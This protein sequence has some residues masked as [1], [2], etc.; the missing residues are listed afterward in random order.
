MRDVQ[1]AEAREPG[2]REGRAL[3]AALAAESLAGLDVRLR[4]RAV[5]AA[6]SAA[7]RLAERLADGAAA[8]LRARRP[9]APR[10][11]RPRAPR[12]GGRRALPRAAGR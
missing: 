2:V 11:R 10:R 4:R 9:V 7:E 5:R 12:A 1:A 8:A 3:S 6:A